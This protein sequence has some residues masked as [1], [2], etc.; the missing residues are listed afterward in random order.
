MN[1]SYLVSSIVPS[2]WWEPFAPMVIANPLGWGSWRAQDPLVSPL[3]V[4]WIGM[5][6]S[7]AFLCPCCVQ[8]TESHC[9]VF[10]VHPQSVHIDP[11]G[12]CHCILLGSAAGDTG[13]H[14]AHSP[15][16]SMWNPN[17]NIPMWNQNIPVWNRNISMWNQNI[18][19][20]LR[21]RILM[22]DPGT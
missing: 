15:V 2:S 7:E 12:D 19:A 20:G 10:G 3:S 17:L 9:S 4:A 13:N 5:H 16:A 6:P 11:C 18:P 1:N 8:S 22:V 21:G 14:G